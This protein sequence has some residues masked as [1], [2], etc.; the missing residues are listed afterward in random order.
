MQ[1]EKGLI[2]LEGS[3]GSVKKM[4]SQKPDIEW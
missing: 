4:V 3:T 1:A 2:E